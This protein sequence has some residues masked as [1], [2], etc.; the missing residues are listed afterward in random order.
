MRLGSNDGEEGGDRI[1]VEMI[2]AAL[3]CSLKQSGG[4]RG[5]PKVARPCAQTWWP[6][7]KPYIR[8][9]CR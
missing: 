7:G 1:K 5:P 2:V 9:L 8:S 3:W 6:R 4:S